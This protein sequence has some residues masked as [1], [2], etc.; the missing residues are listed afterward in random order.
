MSA[1]NIPGSISDY[2]VQGGTAGFT[3]LGTGEF[4]SLAELRARYSDQELLQI[5]L[6]VF[7]RLGVRR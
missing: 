6:G 3:H 5:P 1:P 7:Q 2:V 4:F